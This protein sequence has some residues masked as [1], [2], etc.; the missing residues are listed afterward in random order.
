MPLLIR[1]ACFCTLC[2]LALLVPGWVAEVQAKGLD[3]LMRYVPKDSEGYVAADHRALM[4]H[5]SGP[6]MMDMVFEQ[7]AGVGLRTLLVRDGRGASVLKRSISFRFRAMAFDLVEGAFD[8]DRLERASRDA[9]KTAFKQ[10]S[11]V[12]RP[13]MTLTREQA[14][15]QLTPGVVVIGPFEGLKLLAEHAKMR[16]TALIKRPGY[17]KV[18]ATARRLNALLWGHSWPSSSTRK[19]LSSEGRG[20]AATTDQVWF[21]ISGKADITLRS[22]VRTTSP[23]DAE[24]LKG[25]LKRE[26][27]ERVQGSMV[28][29]A[30]G[31]AALASR[32]RF[33]VA[34]P[35][36]D[37]RLTLTPSEVKAIARSA[38]KA[39]SVLR[40]G[41]RLK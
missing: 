31:Y 29:R 32:I 34:G 3:A 18:R 5:P 38:G 10:G 9:I 26:V 33:D 14:M 39:L 25:R 11:I 17:Q 4:A 40:S 19:R 20:V 16:H 23:A 24:V 28:L 37:S 7:G 1:R 15:L 12:G 30:L 6:S 41:R 2:L 22:V 21:F 27:E 36:V 8:S 13:W 35:L